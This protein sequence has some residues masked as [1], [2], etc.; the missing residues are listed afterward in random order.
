MTILSQH[1]PHLPPL[2]ASVNHT[3]LGGYIDMG[4]VLPHYYFRQFSKREEFV[5]LWESGLASNVHCS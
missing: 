3:G 2:L 4:Y 5:Y 1:F